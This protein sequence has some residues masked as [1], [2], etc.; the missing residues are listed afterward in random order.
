M[1]DRFKNVMKGMLNQGVSKLET[2]AILAEQAQMELESGLK[3]VKEAVTV[4]VTNEKMLETQLQKNKDDLALWEK[5]AIMAV[6]QNNDDLARQ[7]IAKKKEFSEHV[8]SLTNQLTEQKNSTTAMKQKLSEIEEEYREFKVKKQA[9][10]ARAKAADGV[11]KA[12]E[13]ISGGSAA[14]GGSS[15]D[16][17]EE[18][19]R[20]KENRNEAL[21]EMSGATTEK[22]FSDAAKSLDLDDELAALKAK[23]TTPKL[24]E[25]KTDGK[26]IVDANV[27]MIRKNQPE[28][29]LEVI[30]AEVV[31]ENKP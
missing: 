26:T 7:C 4:A 25:D 1:F 12:N 23:M 31:D 29:E 15:M 10:L 13:L 8:Q 21:K 30:D 14:S 2:P 9:M 6:E 16:K 24:I 5:R 3:K 28:T 11:A 19:I 27:P 20:D 18:K 17:W 22:H